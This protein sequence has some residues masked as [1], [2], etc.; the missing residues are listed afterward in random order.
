MGAFVHTLLKK[1]SHYRAYQTN[2]CFFDKGVQFDKKDLLGMLLSVLLMVQLLY[3][4]DGVKSFPY[5]LQIQDL[6]IQI[7]LVVLH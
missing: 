7:H 2:N 5:R 6:H 1:R 4:H 3:F